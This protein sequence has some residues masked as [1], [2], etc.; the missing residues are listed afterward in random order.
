MNQR[1]KLCL[2][3]PEKNIYW[4]SC[5]ELGNEFY[6]HNDILHGQKYFEAGLFVKELLITEKPSLLR[7][8]DLIKDYNNIGN[9]SK[10]VQ[11]AFAEKCFQKALNLIFEIAYSEENE[12][13]GSKEDFL[14]DYTLTQKICFVS[15][16]VS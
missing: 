10:N 16:K 13:Y 3:E 7:R 11:N 9:I 4:M 5:F 12:T 14:Q 8:R 1:D 15:Q 6:A 2:L